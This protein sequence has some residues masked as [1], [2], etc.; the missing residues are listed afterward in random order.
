[1]NAPDER[2]PRI[3]TESFIAALNELF[4]GDTWEQVSPF[5]ERAWTDFAPDT[6]WQEIEPLVSTEWSKAHDHP[7]S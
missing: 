3:E 5:A 2:P 6:P 4:R 1:M 7:E